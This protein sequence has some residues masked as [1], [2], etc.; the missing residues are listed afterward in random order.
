M[1]AFRPVVDVVAPPGEVVTVYPVIGVPPSFAG[2][3]Q[4]STA[5]L[6]PAVTRRAGGGPGRPGGAP[7][8]TRRPVGAP[9]SPVGVTAAEALDGPPSPSVLVAVTVKV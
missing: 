2:G 7:A 6:S 1:V 4:E 5:R 9:G 3:F 8:V